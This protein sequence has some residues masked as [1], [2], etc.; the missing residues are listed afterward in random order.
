MN[1]EDRFYSES[2]LRGTKSEN[3]END[4]LYSV[5]EVEEISDMF[6]DFYVEHGDNYSDVDQAYNEFIDAYSNVRDTLKTQYIEDNYSQTKESKPKI[7]V[8]N[9]FIKKHSNSNMNSNS[10]SKR[11]DKKITRSAVGL[12]GGA[13]GYGIASL[14]NKKAKAEI[15]D[16]EDKMVTGNAKASDIQKLEKLKKKIKLRKAL[17]TAAGAAA[18]VGATKLASKFYSEKQFSCKSKAEDFY[19][20]KNQ[21]AAAALTGAGAMALGSYLGKKLGKKVNPIAKVKLE[22]QLSKLEQI[23][24]SKNKQGNKTPNL[25]KKIKNL[26]DRLKEVS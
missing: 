5:Y 20:N 23:K 4:T 14:S 26:K 1:L 12:A 2:E 25:D 18:G 19:A 7:R 10:N 13:A 17:G 21:L 16:I 11:V 15:K 22:K 6:S 24:A 8:K 9:F 3:P